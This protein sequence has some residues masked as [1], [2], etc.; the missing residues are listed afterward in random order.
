MKNAITMQP[1]RRKQVTAVPGLDHVALLAFLE[2]QEDVAAVY[3]FGSP[4]QGRAMNVV[5]AAAEFLFGSPAQGRATSARTSTLPLIS[6]RIRTND[7]LLHV[8]AFA[9]IAVDLA[10]GIHHGRTDRAGSVQLAGQRC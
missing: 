1:L 6:S 2:T 8:P 9:P 5:R 3:L 7:Q 4:A 10:A